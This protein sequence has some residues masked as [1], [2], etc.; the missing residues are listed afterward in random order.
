MYCSKCGSDISDGQRFCTECGAEQMLTQTEK[1]GENVYCSN[2]G[3]LIQNNNFCTN[4]GN[5]LNEEENTELNDSMHK[6]RRRG[7]LV[8]ILIACCAIVV[9]FGLY[10]GINYFMNG[11]YDSF[12]TVSATETTGNI[13]VDVS[14]ITE[15]V[16]DE[17]SAY[18]VLNYV[19]GIFGFED[20]R[21][22]LDIQKTNCVNGDTYYRFAQK[23]KEIP[24][25]GKSIVLSAD[26]NGNVFNISGN[27]VAIDETV[28]TEPKIKLE[29]AKKKIEKQAKKKLK[30]GISIL[31]P[32]KVVYFHDDLFVLAWKTVVS[33]YDKEGN[34]SSYAIVADANNGEVI[35]KES[36]IINEQVEKTLSGAN[37]G[38]QNVT[39][40][41][42][43]TADGA[44]HFQLWDKSRNISIYEPIDKYY[45]YWAED[46]GIKDGK[47]VRQLV[48]WEEGET[49]N[50]SAVD[51]M[52]N[53]SRTYDYYDS[54]LYHRGMDGNGGEIPV[55][56]N[57]SA[58]AYEEDGET[59]TKDWYDNAFYSPAYKSISFTMRTKEYWYGKD[60]DKNGVEFSANLDTVA[61]EY[62]HGVI[63]EI[64][65][66]GSH[67]VQRA[68]HEGY[69]DIMGECVEDSLENVDTDWVHGERNIMSPSGAYMSMYDPNMELLP[70]EDYDGKAYEA[71]TIISHAAYLMWSGANS[72]E[73]AISDTE[74][75]AK[76]WYGSIYMLN[77][78]S[79]FTHCRTAV[80][81]S[82]ERLLAK[83][84]LTPEQ[85]ECVSLAFE[86]V[87]IGE[88]MLCDT[89]AIN[90]E[91][92]VY[93]ANNSEY[94]N[95]HYEV[96]KISINNL[97]SVGKAVETDVK[98]VEEGDVTEEKVVNLTSLNQDS[99]HK[100]AYRITISDLSDEPGEVQ[101]K[102]VVVSDAQ[103]AK[104]VLPFYT[105]YVPPVG[106]L[107]EKINVALDDVKSVHLS[108]NTTSDY[109]VMGSKVNMGISLESDV[110]L[111][112]G[113]MHTNMTTKYGGRNIA[114]EIYIKTSGNTSDIYMST[115]GMWVKQTGISA[116][117]LYKLG[118]GFEGVDGIKFYLNSM[119]NVYLESDSD[120]QNYIISGVIGSKATEEALKKAGLSTII[121]QLDDND[122]ISKS[123]IQSML[124]NLAPMKV[125][126]LISKDTFLPTQMTI[127]M[128]DTTE[129]IYSN[130][131]SIAAKYGE[132]I[133]YSISTNKAVTDFSK[134]N[135][136][137]EIFIPDEAVNGTDYKIVK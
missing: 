73:S 93:A 9:G 63:D 34:F 103:D 35:G 26:E 99:S 24:V 132:S 48:S 42:F 58:Q 15:K 137:S 126:F 78:D 53:V 43:E 44:T 16:T 19:S 36:Q 2:C 12:E 116:S 17:E 120:E 86:Q 133:S 127:D 102:F 45:W 74:V 128:K 110:N 98:V 124:S 52:A 39:V 83:N 67:G 121:D 94:Y 50:K 1:N 28:D 123:D 40:E 7:K 41:K 109:T 130:M 80:E 76:L 11:M 135:G 70:N 55:F 3:E 95:Y 114:N 105:D 108:Q 60:Y 18:E 57:I 119:E 56:V 64:A 13:V 59:K 129:S 79:D 97:Y 47:K 107:L 96:E 4:C 100:C 75:L 84:I 14:N 49:P 46:D 68:L 23:Y 38:S 72:T 85:V 5:K 131:K 8:P 92:H 118:S 6:K 115:S 125:M 69:A 25:Y 51:A 134:Y 71:S 29:N 82:A 91:L 66:L 101:S 106:E 21:D 136:L 32:E 20:A 81:I 90:P 33:G 117:D 61:H 112:N 65:N 87:G 88:G 122:E 104:G 89:V 54:I 111:T 113:I 77:A 31:Q 30:N 22:V 10:F 62:T 37:D 27:Y